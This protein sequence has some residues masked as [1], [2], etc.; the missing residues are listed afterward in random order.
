MKTNTHKGAC[1]RSADARRCVFGAV[2]MKVNSFVTAEGRRG[3][4][5]GCGKEQECHGGGRWQG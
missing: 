3:A 1:E 4:R 5:G 2:G